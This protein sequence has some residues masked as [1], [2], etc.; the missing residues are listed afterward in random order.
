V[1]LWTVR[2]NTRGRERER[3]R[4]RKRERERER[5]RRRDGFLGA[6]APWGFFEEEG[7]D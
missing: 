6:E 4:E 3:E 5:E 1:E 2:V 7:A